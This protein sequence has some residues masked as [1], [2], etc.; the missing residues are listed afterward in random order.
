[1]KKSLVL[2]TLVAAAA[3]AACGKQETPP[4]PATTPAVEAPVPAAAPMP[5]EPASAPADAASAPMPADAASAPAM[6][7]PSTTEAPKQ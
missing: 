7:M 6:P 2:A 5:T 3:L 1:M 4:A